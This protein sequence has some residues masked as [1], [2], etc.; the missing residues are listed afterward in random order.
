MHCPMS[1]NFPW[2]MWVASLV[3]DLSGEMRPYLPL[4]KRYTCQFIVWLGERVQ[5]QVQIDYVRFGS[6]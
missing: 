3:W 4:S 1:S 2:V 5:T 6:S